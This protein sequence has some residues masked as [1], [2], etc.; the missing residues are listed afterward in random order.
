MFEIYSIFH[1]SFHTLCS[2]LAEIFSNESW[3]YLSETFRKEWLSTLALVHSRLY[4]QLRRRPKHHIRRSSRC[5]SS[6][7]NLTRFGAKKERKT[8]SFFATL[9][10]GATVAHRERLPNPWVLLVE[11]KNNGGRESVRIHISDPQFHAPVSVHRS[12]SYNIPKLKHPR[13][14]SSICC[15]WFQG[16]SHILTSTRLS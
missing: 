10:I 8:R 13:I 12:I 7:T 4:E 14:S 11:R 1:F 16:S 9:P 15:K 2:I 5:T 3:R 6:H